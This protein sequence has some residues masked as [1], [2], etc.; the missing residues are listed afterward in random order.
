M[1]VRPPDRPL[2][3]PMVIET[4]IGSRVVDRRPLVRGQWE[5]VLIPVRQVAAAPFRRIDVRAT[6]AW[7]DKRRLAQRAS[8]IDVAAT[9]MVSEM[10]WL[11]PGAR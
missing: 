11:G 9:V 4:I 3:R 6:P 8:E 7:M 10:R 1:T 5:T 2:P